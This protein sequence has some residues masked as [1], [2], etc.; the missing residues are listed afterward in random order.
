MKK[1]LFF[2]LFNL[3]L[4]FSLNAV[5][6][7]PR[8]A[9]FTQPSCMAVKVSPNGKQLAYVG[10]NQEGVMNLF[11]APNL[12]L[13]GTQLTDFKEPAIGGFYWS[14]NNQK[15]L[16][17]K[18]KD[19]TRQYHLY[20]FDLAS[21]EL[22]N[23][24]ACY[25]SISAKVFRM[26]A[27]EN[28]AIIGIN[29]RNPLFHDLYILNLDD[30]SLSLIY[31][32]DH[33]IHFVFDDHL[34]IAVKVRMNPD[35]SWTVMAKNDQVLLMITAEDAFSTEFLKYNEKD[36]S[37]YLLDNRVSNTT[38]LKKIYLNGRQQDVVLGHDIRSD[39]HD[40]LFENGDPI[41]YA[42]YFTYKE[43]HPLNE[44]AKHDL[45]DLV[46]KIGT[47][48]SLINQSGDG[49]IWILRN[50][51]P[52]KGVTFWL[53]N[54]SLQELS[55]LYSFPNIES[56]AKTYPLVLAA[57]DGMQLVS[58]LTLPKEMDQG[59]RPQKSIPL[60]VFPHG[61]PFKLR[62]CYDYSPVHQWLAN[63]GYA[64]LSVNFRLSSGFGK[65]FVNA[66]NRQWGK[67]AHEDILDAVQ[68]CIENG[69][70]EKDKI[71]IYGG[72]YGGYEALASLTFSPNVFACAV[73]I[74]GPSNLKTVLS[75]V[76][77]YWEFPASP[78]SDN[79]VAFTKNAFIKSMGGDPDK[80]SDQAF[81][82]SCSPLNYVDQIQRPLLLVHGAND[83][84]VAASESD[85]IFEKMKQ[86]QLPVLYLSFPDEGHGI[87]KFANEMCQ[88]AYS[89]WLLAKILG[90]RY[91]PITQEQINLSSA[92][93]RSHQIS[94]WDIIKR[95]EE[96]S[97]LAQ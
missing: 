36:H 45:K 91:E 81:L 94:H 82:E 23:L 4:F 70:A 84:I 48:F 68:W 72:S 46:S 17:L 33:F 31:Q 44:K 15:I 29:H 38:Q 40:V 26:G 24:T 97:Y 12:S 96:I 80:E 87:S 89:E 90:G 59:G 74:C 42:T 75:K 53:Y 39:I 62:D 55:A 28:K 2:L 51:I 18:D 54:R 11:A 58:Y 3:T 57:K 22:K 27:T 32:N 19:G 64:V 79:M 1:S 35:S 76:P 10:A 63:R 83:P 56:F 66:G 13:E 67:K 43:W 25:G 16:F 77:F 6:L 69:I 92:R 78:L 52:E 50:S 5:D 85:Q 41:A 20:S 86:R 47:N 37:L 88:L 9:L 14:P 95:K 34:E 71:A 61:G 60:V 93:I 21:S 7:I 73:A 49:Q 65:E 8:E 30:G